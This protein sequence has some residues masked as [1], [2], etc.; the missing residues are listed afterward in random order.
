MKIVRTTYLSLG[1]NLG[2][3]QKTLQIAVEQISEKIG[4]VTKI[5]SIYKTKALGFE[6]D[7]FFNICIEVTTNLNP[8]SLI[9]SVLQIETSLGRERLNT[10]NYHN[11]NIDIDILLFDDDI[12][13]YNDLKVPHPRMLERKFVLVP[14]TEIA[15]NVIHPIAKKTILICLKNC[16][17]NSEIIKVNEK[18][19]R[20]ISLFEKYNY[21]AIEGNIGSGKTSLAKMI[22]D[23][24][25]AKLVLERFAD[26]PF[27]P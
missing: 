3:K 2:N 8:E 5:S 18:I 1:S 21:I 7:D 15:P 17:D 10:S 9:K 12:I 24:F 20:P 6:G 11:R 26:N 27:L 23:D 4:R 16:N 22:G 14:L 25:N 19:N 13:F